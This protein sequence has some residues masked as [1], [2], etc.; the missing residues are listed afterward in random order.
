MLGFTG[1][2]RVPNLDTVTRENWKLPFNADCLSLFVLFAACDTVNRVRSL[3]MAWAKA[4]GKHMH[5]L[6]VGDVFD[7]LDEIEEHGVEALKLPVERIV[8]EIPTTARLA[9]VLGIGSGLKN[10]VIFSIKHAL[11]HAMVLPPEMALAAH[12][13]SLGT[14]PTFQYNSDRNIGMMAKELGEPPPKDS[15]PKVQEAAERQL[16][17]VLSFDDT[18]TRLRHAIDGYNTVG[19]LM[20]EH[21]T[22]FDEYFKRL[23]KKRAAEGTAEE[24][25]DKIEDATE[26]EKAGESAKAAPFEEP[27]PPRDGGSPKA[28]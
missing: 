17:H 13:R 20:V 7:L 22:L 19:L 2:D 25:E 21:M 27:Q 5:L 12:I 28:H 16:V 15:W 18:K 24:A 1:L 11:G 14:A 4:V 8:E 10:E 6:T 26:A 23:R 9:F 3:L